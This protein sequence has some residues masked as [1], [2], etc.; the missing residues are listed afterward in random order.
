MLDTSQDGEG[1]SGDENVGKTRRTHKSDIAF[2]LKK[3]VSVKSSAYMELVA[4]SLGGEATVRAFCRGQWLRSRIWTKSQLKKS[5]GMPKIPKVMR[6]GSLLIV[7]NRL[8][9]VIYIKLSGISQ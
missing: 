1:G 3:G 9:M 4:K 2:K 7:I 5:Y 8:D 6:W